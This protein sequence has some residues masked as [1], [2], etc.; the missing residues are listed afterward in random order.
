MRSGPSDQV[1]VAAALAVELLAEHAHGEADRL[2]V[3]GLR[4]PVVELWVGRARPLRLQPPRATEQ[5]VL[6]LRGEPAQDVDGL[7]L[8]QVLRALIPEDEP[9]A[10]DRVRTDV[11]E[12]QVLGHMLG[13]AEVARMYVQHIDRR[14]A[15]LGREVGVPP[16][17]RVSAVADV[18]ERGDAAEQVARSFLEELECRA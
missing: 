18:H 11:A 6:V 7:G 1:A 4:A 10:R 9:E 5:D 15:E 17:V 8:G 12:A 13:G 3:D 16:R 2:K 14:P